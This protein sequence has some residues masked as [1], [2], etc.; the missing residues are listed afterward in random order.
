MTKVVI[1]KCHGGFGLSKAGQALFKEQ[2][3]EDFDEFHV[4]RDDEALVHVVET[5]GDRANDSYSDLKVVEV[6]DEVQWTIEEYDGVE[7]VAEV[8]RTWR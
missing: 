4:Y 8:H 7:W 3:G 6:P 1:N 2:S 5:L